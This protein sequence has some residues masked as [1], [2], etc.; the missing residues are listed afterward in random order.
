VALAKPRQRR[1]IRHLVRGDHPTGDVF[2]TRT[3]DRPRRPRSARVGV[4]QD[5]DHH[6]RIKRRPAVT[7]SAISAIERRQIHA[8]HDVDHKPREVILRQPL[9]HVGRQQKRLLAIT[10]DEVL[11]HHGSLLNPP[12][13]HGVHRRWPA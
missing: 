13:N 7:V 1:V 9:T 10:R 8:R 2:L 4:E 11:A 5:R 12:D 3:L 6:R